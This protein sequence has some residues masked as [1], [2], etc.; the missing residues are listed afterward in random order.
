MNNGIKK[1]LFGIHQG[2]GKTA[3]AFYNV[4][5]LTDYFQR[6]N[7]IPKFYFI[8]D[9]IDLADQAKTNLPIEA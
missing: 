9:R 4:Q 8:V 5:L 2:S 7:I 6:R 1:V 3:L